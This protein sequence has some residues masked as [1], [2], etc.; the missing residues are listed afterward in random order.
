VILSRHLF[1]AF[2]RYQNRKFHFNISA[3]M[4]D[5]GA[6]RGYTFHGTN[7]MLYRKWSRW[8]YWV[9]EWPGHWPREVMRLAAFHQLAVPASQFS[10]PREL[11]GAFWSSD[12]PGVH[13]PPSQFRARPPAIACRNP[14]GD[15]RPSRE[16]HGGR[17]PALIGG[18][19]AP[20]TRSAGASPDEPELAPP[21]PPRK[22]GCSAG[23]STH[24][25]ARKFFHRLAE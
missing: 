25:A 20:K 8:Q 15:A 11:S 3:R 6:H 18:R 24:S 16:R 19:S 14:D 10:G 1:Y 23:R 12:R 22:G 13:P 2:T 4:T 9:W 21:A 5:K 7:A 17:N